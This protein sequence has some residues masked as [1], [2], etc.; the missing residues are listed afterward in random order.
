MKPAGL[1]TA[2]C[3]CSQL[4]CSC[5]KQSAQPFTEQTLQRYHTARTF[6]SE[7]RLD[8]ALPL[9]LENFGS[10]PSFCANSFL[11]G[12]IYYFKGDRSQAERYW[13]HTL[14]VNPHHLD[15]RKWLARLYL[16][17]QRSREAQVVLIDALAV[18]SEDPELLLLLAKA[19][20]GQQDLAGAIELYRKS[21]AFVERL[22]E[23][24]LDLAEIYYSFGLD[25][26]A[27]EQLRKALALLGDNSSLYP[28]IAA[29]LEQLRRKVSQG[30]GP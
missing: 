30:H 10:A 20:R 14:T 25:D 26:R 21:Q 15:T 2:A 4:V 28:S 27:E 22:S 6:Y 11:I 24:S 18:S 1:L 5:A 29:A 17:Q 9:L 13:S 16:Q 19:K 12:K 23:A 8:E 3:I 7:Q